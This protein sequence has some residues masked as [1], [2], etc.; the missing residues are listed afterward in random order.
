MPR[1]K[2]NQKYAY[3]KRAAKRFLEGTNCSSPV[4]AVEKGIRS[5]S[6]W[7]VVLLDE[8]ELDQEMREADAVLRRKQRLFRRR[9]M[10]Q[11]RVL[12]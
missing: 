5:L 7:A 1:P 8:L 3:V 11:P 12:N 10:K 9:A 4:L 6:D 2:L